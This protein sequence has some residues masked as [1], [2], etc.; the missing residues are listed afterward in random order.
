[1]KAKYV[2]VLVL[3]TLILLGW[4]LVHY[5][6]LDSRQFRLD[7]L[8]KLP[9]YVYLNDIAQMDSLA[10]QLENSIPE[11]DSLGMESGIQAAME[12][13]EEYPDLGIQPNTLRD[14][15]FPNILTVTFEP[16]D[17]AFPAR[18][19]LL[20]LLRDKMIPATDIDNQDPA[21]TLVKNELDF[22]N[23][24]WS[25]STLF[26]ALTV[27]LMMLFA[28]LYLYLSDA[29]KTKGIRATVLESIRSSEAAR[30]QNV[31][32]VAVPVIINVVLYYLLLAFG[33]ISPLIHW[34]F[35]LIQF[36]SAGAA[37]L[38]AFLIHGMHGGEGS[39]PS[40]TV[41]VPTKNDALDS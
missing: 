19:K 28:R 38:V 30:W 40:I 17:A 21:W 12:L 18:E 3:S 10:L 37:V 14:Y 25:N 13:L 4:T 8:S 27:F 1:M 5:Q 26:I 9:V 31:L 36:L 39:A 34:T 7:Q 6:Y 24:R 15:Q 11:I 23:R 41:T 32:L 35:F 2:L 29:G 22:L 16:A 20:E 33:A